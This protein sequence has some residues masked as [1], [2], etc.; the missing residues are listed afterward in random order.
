[1]EQERHTDG[2]SDARP[3]LITLLA[4]NERP[5]GEKQHGVAHENPDAYFEATVILPTMP[6]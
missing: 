2:Q 6:A 1:M 4:A 3:G 5:Q